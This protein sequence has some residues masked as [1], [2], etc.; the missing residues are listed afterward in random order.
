MIIRTK[1][2]GIQMRNEKLGM[3]NGGNYDYQN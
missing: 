2:G 1:S 3:R